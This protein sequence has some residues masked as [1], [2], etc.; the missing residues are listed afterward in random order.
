[1]KQMTMSGLVVTI[2][3]YLQPPPASGAH[4]NTGPFLDRQSRGNLAL[5]F[6]MHRICQNLPG[7]TSAPSTESR[8]LDMSLAGVYVETPFFTDM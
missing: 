7:F 2:M 4:Y 5:Y 1:M 8:L 6:S 3:V